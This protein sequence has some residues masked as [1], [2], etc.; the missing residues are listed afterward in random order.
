MKAVLSIVLG[1]VMVLGQFAA[2]APNPGAAGVLPC[3]CPS[4]AQ[5]NCCDT[6]SPSTPLAPPAPS[7]AD[8]RV[9]APALIVIAVLSAPEA[10]SSSIALLSCERSLS[11]R[12]AVPVY[13]RNCSY[14]I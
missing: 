5:F 14:L 4:C 10:A 11:Q 6:T 2:A 13:D 3:D 7:S 8:F 1:I 9:Q 12:A